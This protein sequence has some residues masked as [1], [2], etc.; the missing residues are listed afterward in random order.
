LT[1]ALDFYRI[2]GHCSDHIEIFR[3]HS[4]LYKLLAF[5]EADLERQCKMHKRRA[6]LLSAV[7]DQLNP[8]YYLLVCRQ[9]MFEL[10]E[11]YSAMLD[12]KLAIIELQAGTPVATPPEHSRKKINALTRQSIDKFQVGVWLLGTCAGA[13][14][15][16][17]FC[18]SHCLST[19]QM[20]PSPSLV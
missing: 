9:L 11:I 1:I 2:D 19:R 4:T 8:Q 7:L 5:F 3:D 10:A 13:A 15:F 6:D 20:Y 17:G 16:V 14:F 18:F 12:N